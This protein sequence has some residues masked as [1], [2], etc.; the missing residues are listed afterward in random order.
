MGPRKSKKFGKK[1][2]VFIGNSD[3]ENTLAT[4]FMAKMEK[5]GNMNISNDNEEG[6]DNS[7]L[8]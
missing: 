2:K 5:L 7:Y 8:S 1:K 4:G 3:V 6:G